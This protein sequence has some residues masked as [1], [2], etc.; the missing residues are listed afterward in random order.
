[1]RC[2]LLFN[3]FFAETYMLCHIKDL[4][5]QCLYSFRKPQRVE[6]GQTYTYNKA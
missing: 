4:L 5:L 2:L 6:E 3:N 1:M